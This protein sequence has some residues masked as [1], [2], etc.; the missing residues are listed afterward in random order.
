MT[1]RHSTRLDLKLCF[2]GFQ[3]LSKDVTFDYI[4]SVT[5]QHFLIRTRKMKLNSKRFCLG[6]LI[7][8][9]FS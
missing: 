2:L 3:T 8:F 1:F 9:D 5:R 7:S 6:D 4:L